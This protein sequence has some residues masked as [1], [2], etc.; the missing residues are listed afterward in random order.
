MVNVAKLLL[1]TAL[2]KSGLVV[3]KLFPPQ[4][5]IAPVPVPSVQWRVNPPART[6]GSDEIGAYG[7]GPKSPAPP[8]NGSK[9]QPLINAACAVALHDIKPTNSNT[10]DNIRN[11]IAISLSSNNGTT[12]VILFDNVSSARQSSYQLLK[13]TVA[14]LLAGLMRRPAENANRSKSRSKRP[15]SAHH[16][17]K[18]DRRDVLANDSARHLD[19]VKISEIGNWRHATS[20]GK[21]GRPGSSPS[22]HDDGTCDV[23]AGFHWYLAG[24]LTD[25][26][27]LLKTAGRKGPLS[28]VTCCGVGSSSASPS[29][30]NT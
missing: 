16:A 21:M 17:Q 10:N 20:C 26:R 18:N 2:S 13:T 6:F 27:A 8:V 19:S 5:F 11:F 1:E 29:D 7:L 12:R 24:I 22:S 25:G 3:L 15:D 4:A 14:G 28:P 30:R 9:S 23:V